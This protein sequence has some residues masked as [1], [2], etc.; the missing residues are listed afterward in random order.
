MKHPRN[1]HGPKACTPIPSASLT[2]FTP[3]EVA[4]ITLM[5]LTG[6]A[7]FRF[8]IILLLFIIGGGLAR[9]GVF[10]IKCSG[11][12]RVRSAVDLGLWYTVRLGARL[13]MYVAGF[14]YV[15]TDGDHDSRSRL[16]ISTHSSLWDGVWLLFY[17]GATQAAKHELFSLPFIGDYLRLMKSVPVDRNSDD[18]RRRAMVE[19]QR[20]AADPSSPPLVVF[21]TACCCNCRQ[22]IHFKRGAFE[23]LCPIQPI[24]IA[25]PSRHYDMKLSKWA[26]WDLYRSVCQF[27]NTM[28]VTFLP[29][30]IPNEQERAD[31]SLWSSK[32]RSE[33]ASK[34]GMQ[35][36]DYRYED[37]IIRTL[38]RDKNVYLNE[39]KLHI[40]DFRLVEK[41]V[42]AFALIDSDNDGWISFEDFQS[43]RGP[44]DFTREQYQHILTV[45][46]L[47]PIPDSEYSDP[48]NFP[49]T[50]SWTEQGFIRWL[51]GG[52]P[53]LCPR[54]RDVYFSTKF[55]FA[56]IVTYV[57]KVVDKSSERIDSVLEIFGLSSDI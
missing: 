39:L 18:G 57:N 13:I 51:T 7:P 43:A 15:F 55:E 38:C 24:G 29:V 31:S 14:F 20:R 10:C 4:R 41:C 37:E 49:N 42:N 28:T 46:K 33:M 11:S 27:T 44:G 34:L 12:N 30:R 36:V 1:I 32:V 3:Y 5:T 48:R 2:R 56:E 25:Y 52:R 9:L 8:L 47:P 50:D 17:L 54:P 53:K 23:P 40:V 26:L 16:I 6:I 22:L 19:I 21:P 45:I 35:L